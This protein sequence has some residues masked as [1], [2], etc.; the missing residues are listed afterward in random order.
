MQIR[1]RHKLL[2]AGAAVAAVAGAGGAIAATQSGGTPRQAF[3]N[4]A[5]GRLHVSPQQLDGALKGA[6]LDRLNQ[7]VK[8]GRLTQAQADRIRQRANSGAMPWFGHERGRFGHERGHFRGGH[9]ARHGLLAAAA[10]YLDLTPQQLRTQLRSGKT[11]AQIAQ[12]RG[13]SVEGLKTALSTA[14]KTRLDRAV[15]HGRLSS[16]REQRILARLPQL[17]DRLVNRPLGH[18]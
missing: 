2:A 7:A 18:H 13:K 10:H 8:D 14:I 1:S 9:L 3:L 5:A 16:T 15:A 11:L 4:D 6:F 17:L 12:A